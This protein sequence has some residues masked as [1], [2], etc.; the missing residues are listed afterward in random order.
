MSMIEGDML[1]TL[2]DPDKQLLEV[3]KHFMWVSVG[4]SVTL[5]ATAAAEIPNTR[6]EAY[7]PGWYAV[8]FILQ[9]AITPAGL[10]LLIGKTWRTLPL[11]Y[12]LNTAFGFLAA[13]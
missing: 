8:W 9:V 10:A 12:R 13:A 4:A 2:N 1:M 6:Y 5:L 11:S 3:W 7:F